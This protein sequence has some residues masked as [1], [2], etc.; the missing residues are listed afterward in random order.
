MY[1]LDDHKSK[2]DGDYIMAQIIAVIDKHI[3][4]CRGPFELDTSDQQHQPWPATILL[5]DL[6]STL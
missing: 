1:P 5:E 6:P 2:E 4:H 3:S